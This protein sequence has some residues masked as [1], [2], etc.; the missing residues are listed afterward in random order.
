MSN[1]TRKKCI[2]SILDYKQSYKA[3]RTPYCWV[4]PIK[5]MFPSQC[6]HCFTLS[7]LSVRT[8]YNIYVSMFSYMCR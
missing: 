1:P 2:A 5:A 7:I 3:R 4:L 6:A 8:Y